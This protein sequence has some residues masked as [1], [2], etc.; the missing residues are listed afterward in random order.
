M[1]TVEN[2]IETTGFIEKYDIEMVFVE[3][4]TFT[5]GATSEQG[6]DCNEEKPAHQVTVSSF[7]ISKYT[8]TQAQWKAVMNHNPSFFDGDNLPVEMINWDDIHEF[9]RKLNE[10]TGNLYRLP[11]EAEWEFAARGGNK[12]KGFRYS[13]SDSIADVAWYEDNSEDKTHPVGIK[14]PNE[15][16]IYD[17]SGNVWEWC[18]DWFGDYPASPQINPKGPD[19]GSI[20]VLRGGG[21]SSRARVCRVAHRIILAPSFRY[22]R[23]GLRLVKE[24]YYQAN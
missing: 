17:M 7:W 10:Q 9:I 20:R 3:G 4:G 19:T 15:L 12:S 16:G 22:S 8:I 23:S 13:G 14:V 24:N 11:T 21:W 18:N 1:D 5:M 6:D 2:S